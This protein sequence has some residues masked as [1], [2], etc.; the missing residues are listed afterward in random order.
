MQGTS[1]RAWEVV[2]LSVS[3]GA[4]LNALV[5]LLVLA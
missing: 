5:T 4:L 3:L 2:V 1:W